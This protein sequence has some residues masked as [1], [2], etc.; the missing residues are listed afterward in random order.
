LPGSDLDNT[1]AGRILVS[2]VVAHVVPP[3]LL[4]HYDHNKIL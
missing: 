2:L 1:L 3:H 4:L